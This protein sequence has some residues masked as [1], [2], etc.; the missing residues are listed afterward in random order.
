MPEEGACECHITNPP[1][2]CIS[3]TTRNSL[4]PHWPQYPQSEKNNHS[5]QSKP[6]RWTTKEPRKYKI[7]LFF[8]MVTCKSKVFD[9]HGDVQIHLSIV[10]IKFQVPWVGN[11]K[12][13]LNITSACL[14]PYISQDSLS[15]SLQS[16]VWDEG[17]QSTTKPPSEKLL[18]LYWTDF[19]K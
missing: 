7:K 4:V 3:R 1:P 14:N 6:N 10:E 2:A 19:K 9:T 18:V 11:T 15:T 17:A 16:W 12:K 5:P 8:I 13:V